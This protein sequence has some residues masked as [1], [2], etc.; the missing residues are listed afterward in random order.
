MA[1]ETPDAHLSASQA[2]N[3]DLDNETLTPLEQEVLDEYAR[4]LGNLNNVRLPPPLHLPRIPIS[5]QHRMANDCCP[6]VHSPPRP[7]EQAQRSD[8]RWPTRPGEENEFGV[9]VA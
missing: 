6:D 3:A 9:Y 2:S 7:V 5:H 4:L 8:T 1:S